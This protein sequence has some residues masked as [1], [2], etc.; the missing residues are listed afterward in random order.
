MVAWSLSCAPPA[1]WKPTQLQRESFQGGVSPARATLVL[2]TGESLL[3]EKPVVSHDSLI[4]VWP[5]GSRRR[6]LSL[7]RPDDG[8]STE[9]HSVATSHVKAIVVE[10]EPAPGAGGV[11]FV[12]GWTAAVVMGVLLIRQGI[13]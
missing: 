11:I 1:S 6:G 5:H 10:R 8:D 9:R 4:C 12:L 7:D 13:T 3:V 2:V